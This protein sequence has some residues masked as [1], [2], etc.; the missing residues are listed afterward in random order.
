MKAKNVA[1][2]GLAGVVLVALLI[3]NLSE[4]KVASRRE[5]PAHHNAHTPSPATPAP[6]TTPGAPATS[7]V[8][9]PA[10]RVPHFHARLEDALP[11][12]QIMPASNFSIPVVARAYRIAA[13]IPDV[14]AQQPCYCW[15]DKM[16]HGSLVDCFAT[17]HGAG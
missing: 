6:A 11:L 2:I 15:C 8:E 13:R 9:A 7:V 3:A 1:L 16:G 14:L 10:Q 17:S 4:D 12:P 5:T